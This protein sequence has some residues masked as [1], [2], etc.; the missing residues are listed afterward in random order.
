MKAIHKFLLLFL[1]L[2][3]SNTLSA[4]ISD[5]IK[6][7]CRKCQEKMENPKGIDI[8]MDVKVLI[9]KMHVRAITKGEKALM[10]SSTKVL[11]KSIVMEM[12]FDGQQEWTYDSTQD[13]LTITKADKKPERE[14]DLDFDLISKYKTAKMK[15]KDGVY[16]ITF[17]NPIDKEEANKAVMKIN[18][19]NYYLSGMQIGSGMKSVTFKVNKIKV[20]GISEDIFVPEKRHPTAKIARK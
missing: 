13:S 9:I 11:G 1:L 20:G 4:Q 5:E 18:K 8:D 16:E 10:I 17:T 15:E 7:I 3:G 19:S 14:D 2:L 12:G 6:D